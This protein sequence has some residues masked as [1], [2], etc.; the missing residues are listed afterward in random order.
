[1]HSDTLLP[2]TADTK[3]DMCS[4]TLVHNMTFVLTPY[5]PHTA[6]T[7]HG[8]YSDTLIII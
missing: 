3:H 2:Y 5:S 8:M 6:A 7:Y 4:D 1:M